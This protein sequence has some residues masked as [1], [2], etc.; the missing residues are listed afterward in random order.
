MLRIGL[1]MGFC[2][3]FLQASGLQNTSMAEAQDAGVM[4]ASFF[5]GPSLACWTMLVTFQPRLVCFFGAGHDA[6]GFAN[7]SLGPGHSFREANFAQ[8]V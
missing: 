7:W 2:R 4:D 3:R 5:Q 8:H 1:H 6:V